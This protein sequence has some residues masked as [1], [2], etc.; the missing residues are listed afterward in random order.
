MN[1]NS[2]ADQK[3]L[4]T[5]LRTKEEAANFLRCSQRQIEVM[6]DQWRNRLENNPE[7]RILPSAPSIGLRPTPI[8]KRLVYWDERDLREYLWNARR[9]LEGKDPA[10]L[11][12]KS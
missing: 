4:M 2:K 1:R 6:S 7:P 9:E 12:E 10:K 11:E 3:T 8:S 5:P